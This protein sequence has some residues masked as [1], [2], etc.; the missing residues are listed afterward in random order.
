MSTSATPSATAL[1]S[2]SSCVSVSDARVGAWERFCYRIV[3]FA[4]DVI[5]AICKD[6]ETVSEICEI[7]LGDMV[8]NNIPYE[9]M[10]YFCIKR[11][12]S[13]GFKHISNN[14][15]L[16]EFPE[17]DH[18]LK[19]RASSIISKYRDYYTVETNVII[20][21]I[22]EIVDYY[23]VWCKRIMFEFWSDAEIEFYTDCLDDTNADTIHELKVPILFP[24]KDGIEIRDC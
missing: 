14:T 7:A 22:Q 15:V 19:Y 8:D 16:P 24:L 1:A 17:F 12:N 9:D 10:I 18:D 5:D 2:S 6:D 3:Y 23:L 4:P 20:D 21:V 13:R 11:V